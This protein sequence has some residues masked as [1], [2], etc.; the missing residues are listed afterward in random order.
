MVHQYLWYFKLLFVSIFR[1]EC[2]QLIL[3]ISKSVI[4]AQFV[5]VSMK[6][7]YK[8]TFLKKME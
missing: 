8:L 7:F 3:D 6:L 5:K 2:L 1:Y 4:D